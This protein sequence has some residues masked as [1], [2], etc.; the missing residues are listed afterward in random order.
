MSTDTPQPPKTIYLITTYRS[1]VALLQN[2]KPVINLYDQEE[3]RTFLLKQESVLS[4]MADVLKDN[5]A[6]TQ[7]KEKIELASIKTSSI[8]ETLVDSAI[9]SFDEKYQKKLNRDSLINLFGS[10]Q[11]IGDTDVYITH[12]WYNK[13]PFNYDTY[14]TNTDLDVKESKHVFLGLLFRFLRKHIS[15]KNCI[16]KLFAHDLDI[17]D[18]RMRGTVVTEQLLS[19][20]LVNIDKEVDEVT[21]YGTIRSLR[22]MIKDGDVYVSQHGNASM[23]YKHVLSRACT[24]NLHDL[25]RYFLE[26]SDQFAKFSLEKITTSIN[27]QR[28]DQQ[29]IRIRLFFTGKGSPSTNNVLD[30]EFQFLAVL[31]QIVNFNH[32]AWKV[33]KRFIPSKFEKLIEDV[34]L[35][36][37]D[38]HANEPEE[39]QKLRRLTQMPMFISSNRKL[40]SK[41]ASES[42]LV[43]ID[44]RARYLD[45]SIWM[46]YV[47]LDNEQCTKLADDARIER[48]NQ[49]KEEE[50]AKQLFPSDFAIYQTANAHEVREF[51]SRLCSNSR[52]INYHT[53]QGK[54]IT[55]FPFCSEER[56]REKANKQ[57]AK[58]KDKIANRRLIMRVL[59]I[60]DK[61]TI[62]KHLKPGNMNKIDI[63]ESVLSQKDAQDAEPGFYVITDTNK[64][65]I[66]DDITDPIIIIEHAHTLTEAKDKLATRK[67]DIIFLDYLL[68][69]NK[70]SK[71]KEKSS[72]TTQLLEEILATHD[73]SLAG[74]LPDRHS[75]EDKLQEAVDHRG[76][77]NK[78]WFFFISTFSSAIREGMRV[79]DMHYSEKLWHA[80]RGACPAITPQ[81][82]RNNFYHLL[83]T[84]LNE[85]TD[86]GG[87]SN[88]KT[89]S[90]IDYLREIFQA[91]DIREKAVRNFNALLQLKSHYKSLFNDYYF[92]KEEEKTDNINNERDNNGSLLVRSLFPDLSCYGFAF[93]EHL[94]HLIYLVAYGNP[95]QSKVMWY[96]YMSIQRVLKKAEKKIAT[97]EKKK[98]NKSKKTFESVCVL[99]ERHLT[100]LISENNS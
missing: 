3:F 50:I 30:L 76:P 98:A 20:S 4:S 52:L 15:D 29:Y 70:E 2:A 82:F 10:I 95:S 6:F 5:E 24:E 39:V 46:R 42:S 88:E 58:F 77:L 34:V 55:P 33:K 69:Y 1:D 93:W 17:F 32:H 94:Q 23:F 59:L 81:L 44:S 80:E 56:N 75:S 89:F 83:N 53:G 16:I 87:D 25:L 14:S 31:T 85:L 48:H 13:F 35:D 36:Q 100:K 86:I 91:S 8:V 73:P 45:S 78:F 22:T 96:E 57:F 40:V 64:K 18:R 90:V 60:D 63:L 99:I 49:T 68:E 37:V 11:Q 26:I 54:N 67:F 27:G 28:K 43:A 62:K 12:N 51:N 84:Q 97:V 65:E 72:Y 66:R 7:Y 61:S 79:S 19:F 47:Q 74:I 21:G 71:K 41:K 38:E 9:E 92:K